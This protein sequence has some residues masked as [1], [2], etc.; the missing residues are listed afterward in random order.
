MAEEWRVL[1]NLII[2]VVQESGR[3]PSIIG[4]DSELTTNWIG[5]A[6]VHFQLE[7]CQRQLIRLCI[8]WE[9]PLAELLPDSSL[10]PW[11]PSEVALIEHKTEMYNEKL[12]DVADEE[13]PI[14]EEDEVDDI[15]VGVL[16]QLDS[17]RI[18]TDVDEIEAD[19]GKM[20]IM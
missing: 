10:P 18:E 20:D 2:S 13:E 16:E 11:G 1:E 8:T 3:T 14:D 17:L 5:N 6:G 9:A 19:A 15:D 7:E 4:I 12:E